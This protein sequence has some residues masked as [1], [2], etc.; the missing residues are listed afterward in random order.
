MCEKTDQKRCIAGIYSIFYL[1][2]PIPCKVALMIDIK[3]I[4]EIWTKAEKCIVESTI[5]LRW[6]MNFETHKIVIIMG[7]F[8]EKN[9]I[10]LIY[11]KL[12]GIR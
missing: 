4:Q 7:Q 12:L 10:F 8:K 5:F 3:D 9:D 6:W 2:P 11:Q 1:Y